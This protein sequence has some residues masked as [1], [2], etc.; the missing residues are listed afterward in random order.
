[1]LNYV[2]LLCVLAVCLGTLWTILKVFL[3]WLVGLHERISEWRR[4]RRGPKTGF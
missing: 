2:I 1:M 4:A 3:D